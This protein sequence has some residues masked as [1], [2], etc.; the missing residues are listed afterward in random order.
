MAFRGL[1]LAL[2]AAGAGARDETSLHGWAVSHFLAP[3]ETVRVILG[4]K[5]EAS[6]LDAFRTYFSEVSDPSSASYGDYL[7]T[8]ELREM[9]APP[10][11][12][13]AAVKQW[14]RENVG[15]GAQMSVNNYEVCQLFEPRVC[16][17][18]SR[19]PRTPR[20]VRRASAR[21]EPR[22][23]TNSHAATRTLTRLT[24]HNTQHPQRTGSP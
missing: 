6:D 9:V 19:A 11:A 17:L 4:V 15:E 14:V 10:A 22:T 24:R 2:L 7:N 16:R 8:D 23:A 20:C 5:H 18:A 12:R 13:V 1:F 3:E 21:H